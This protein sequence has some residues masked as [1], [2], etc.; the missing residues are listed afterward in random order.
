VFISSSRQNK[1]S[2]VEQRS[3]AA[4]PVYQRCLLLRARSPK[5]ALRNSTIPSPSSPLLGGPCGRRKHNEGSASRPGPPHL[6]LV[7]RRFQAQAEK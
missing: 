1:G 4:T 3:E 6:F 5:L 7:V 2:P